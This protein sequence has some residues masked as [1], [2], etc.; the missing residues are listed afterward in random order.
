MTGEPQTPAASTSAF[1]EREVGIRVVSDARRS[2][3]PV[4]LLVGVALRQN[5]RRAQLLVSNVLA[6]HVPTVPGLAIVAA[7]LLGLLVAAEL[8]GAPPPRPLYD[9]LSALLRPPAD[10]NHDGAELASLRADVAEARVEHPE[11]TTIGYAETATGLGQRVAETIGAYYIHSTRHAAGDRVPFAGFE[12][13]HSHATSH[14]LYPARPDWLKPG[15]TVVLVDDELSTGT[16][17]VNTIRALHA[18][19]PQSR[20]VVASLIDLRSEADRRRFDALAESLHTS[21]AVVALGFGSIEL[22]P[23]VSA[24]A[25]AVLAALSPG[26]VTPGSGEVTVLNAA[27]ESHGAVASLENARFGVDARPGMHDDAAA[28]IAAKLLPLLAG[29]RTLL[30]GSEEFIALPL[31]VADHLASSPP[32]VVTS[33]SSIHFSTTTRSPIAPLDRPDYAIASAVTFES[34]DLTSDGFGPRFAYNLTR[35][36]RRFDTIVFLPEPEADRHRM[37][38]ADGVAEALR[39]VCDH[40]IVALLTS[41]PESALHPVSDAEPHRAADPAPAHSEETARP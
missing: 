16:T 35:A 32:D 17:I 34:H 18:A 8:D 23:D 10:G 11:V 15:G 2:L 13:E 31:A 1:A 37:L 3:V 29:T 7:E 36:G 4:E 21:I 12:E 38:A 28:A 26:A 14:Q 22:P 39:R 41:S 5:P 33:P 40:V 9:R 25:A 19:V 30:L 20:W 27:G 24:R 6:K